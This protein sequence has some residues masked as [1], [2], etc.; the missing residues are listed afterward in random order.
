MLQGIV[1]SRTDARINTTHGALGIT[2]ADIHQHA[3]NAFNDPCTATNPREAGVPEIE[4]LYEK[5][6]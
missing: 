2:R 3:V 4:A 5:A 1:G 6:L